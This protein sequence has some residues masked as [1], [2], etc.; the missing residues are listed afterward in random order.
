MTPAQKKRLQK[1]LA[2]MPTIEKLDPKMYAKLQATIRDAVAKTLPEYQ[3]WIKSS[4]VAAD[5]CPTELCSA[6]ANQCPTELC[7]ACSNQ[8]PT[9]NRNID[10]VV[11]NAVNE[12][13]LGA[14]RKALNEQFE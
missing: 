11:V 3:Q 12:A 6:C 13:M 14:I 10:D 1:T 7:S 8:C 2:K 5:D 9:P 4:L